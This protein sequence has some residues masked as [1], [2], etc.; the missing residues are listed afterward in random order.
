MALN[1]LEYVFHNAFKVC[2]F[3]RS[4]VGYWQKAPHPPPLSFCCGSVF[5]NTS[6]S[7]REDLTTLGNETESLLENCIKKDVPREHW[8]VI[9]NLCPSG[10]IPIPH[11]RL[12]RFQ[13]RFRF[14][15]HSQPINFWVEQTDTVMNRPHTWHPPSL[16]E[17]KDWWDKSNVT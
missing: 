7:K 14:D 10:I 6:N 16:H 13:F 4:R 15:R 12:I 2:H 11:G 8:T 1:R 17:I 5:G 3:A 9:K